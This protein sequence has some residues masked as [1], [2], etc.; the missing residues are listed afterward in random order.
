[1][2]A[3]RILSYQHDQAID[4]IISNLM[5][6]SDRPPG[7]NPVRFEYGWTYIPHFTCVRI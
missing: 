3:S 7:M 5:K 2:P 6:L 1:M 4:I